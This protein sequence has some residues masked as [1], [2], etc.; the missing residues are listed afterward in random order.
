MKT[1]FNFTK[2]LIK[3]YL[4]AASKNYSWMYTGCVY[5]PTDLDKKKEV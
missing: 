4:E 5:Y 3:S 1:I 2:K